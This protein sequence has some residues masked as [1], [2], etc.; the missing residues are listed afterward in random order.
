MDLKTYLERRFRRK[1]D[2]V[3]AESLKSRLRPIVA[4]QAVN[5]P[6]L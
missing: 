1:V 6:G 5:V 2:L 3:P 4:R